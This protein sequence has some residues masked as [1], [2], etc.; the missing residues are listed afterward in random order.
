[1][2]PSRPGDFAALFEFQEMN[3]RPGGE[4]GGVFG[5]PADG[6]GDPRAIAG[7]HATSRRKSAVPA[8]AEAFR[9][10]SEVDATR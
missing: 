9:A 6:G 4:I 10:A 8:V 1:V 5:P 3:E 7:F 2:L